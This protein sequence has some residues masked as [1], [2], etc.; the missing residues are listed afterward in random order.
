MAIIKNQSKN[1]LQGSTQKVT[2][3]KVGDRIIVCN[4]ITENKSKS[5]K[6]ISS[7]NSFGRTVQLASAL[8]SLIEFGFDKVKHGTRRNNFVK[9]NND[10]RNYWSMNTTSANEFPLVQ[11]YDAIQDP[12][13]IGNI[14]SASGIIPSI[15]SLE[16]D[17]KGHLNGSIFLARPF[18]MG[19]W[20]HVGLITIYDFGK[21]KVGFL[22]LFSFMPDMN[23]D[24]NL[25]DQNRFILSAETIPG[26]CINNELYPDASLVGAVMTAI[27]THEKEHSNAYFSIVKD[28]R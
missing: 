27:V 4:R 15:S 16:M 28:N 20:V 26:L 22:K 13:F 23:D 24:K 19:D 1:S 7:R 14:L 11:L 5:P 12:N 3:R 17:I 2:Y 10:L 8:D 25:I 9:Q 18:Q 21:E 6:Q